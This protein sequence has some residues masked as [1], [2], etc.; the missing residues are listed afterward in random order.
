M[1]GNRWLIGAAG[2]LTLVLVVWAAAV[3]FINPAEARGFPLS[4]QLQS[5]LQADYSGDGRGV[6]PVFRLSILGEALQD[7][8]LASSDAEDV[9]EELRASYDEPVP[10]ATA[11]NFEGEAPYTATPT[12]TPTKTPTP[13]VTPTATPTSTPRPTSTSIPTATRTP[14]PA[15]PAPTDAIGPVI[16]GGN[17]M[18]APSALSGCSVTIDVADVHVYDTA[19]SSG[20]DWVKIKYRIVG[21]T[22]CLCSSELTLTSGGWMSGSGSS[23][24]GTYQGSV[25]IDLCSAIASICSGSGVMASGMPHGDLAETTADYVIELWFA[26]TDNAGNTTYYHYGDYTMSETCCP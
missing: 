24:D 18:P 5:R 4:F 2:F 3:L 22:T 12:S 11:R 15:T 23:W 17:P 26:A 1:K 13:T 10:T 6:V 8:G 16:T 20:I 25:T 19:P 7:L 9:A 21:Y 14:K